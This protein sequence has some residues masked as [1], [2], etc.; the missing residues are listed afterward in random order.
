MNN[1][2]PVNFAKDRQINRPKKKGQFYVIVDMGT[3]FRKRDLDV[4]GDFDSLCEAEWAK[5][6]L[7]IGIG[8]RLRAYRIK[9]Y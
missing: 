3:F 2:T 7:E 5:D 8:R 4:M 1:K 9:Q 6:E